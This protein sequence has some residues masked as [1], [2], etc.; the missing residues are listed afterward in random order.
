MRKY[1]N[2]IGAGLLVAAIAGCNQSPEF[3]ELES[4]LKFRK[5]E[6]GDT[7]TA[8]MGDVMNLIMT[9][10]LGDSDSVLYDSGDELGYY[11][12]PFTGLP[13]NLQEAFLKCNEGDS[14]Q[15]QMKYS[16]YAAMTGRPFTPADSAKVVNWNIRVR[17]IE[18]ERVVVERIQ[19]EQLEKD[20][21]IIEDYL[22]NNNLE[23]QTTE[24]GIAVVTLESGNGE[25]PKEGDLV[26]VNYAVRLLNGTLIDTSNEALAKENNL[27]NPNRDYAPY[28]F[29]LGRGEVIRG[30][31]LGIPEVD[32]GGKAKLFIPSSLGYGARNNGGPIP[33]NSVLMFDI[34]V[35]D[36]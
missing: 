6:S 18:N 21:T 30:W 13:P 10:T 31:D 3:I 11:M 36:F 14:A 27:Y 25:Y 20:Q 2:I 26:K 22:V 12:N 8:Q 29:T 7:T 9:H 4:G 16:E 33:P 24:D 19:N 32:K 17:E 5:L 1:R 15:I 23:A 35:V 34:E 28:E